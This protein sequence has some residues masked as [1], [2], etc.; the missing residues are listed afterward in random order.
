M[1]FGFD[2]HNLNCEEKNKI[3]LLAEKIL[4]KSSKKL[5]KHVLQNNNEV[6]L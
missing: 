6:F 4:L 2:K 5:T 1:T 3:F